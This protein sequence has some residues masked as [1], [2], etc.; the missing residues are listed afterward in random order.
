MVHLAWSLALLGSCASGLIQPDW[1]ILTDFT[2]TYKV[3]MTNLI[4]IANANSPAGRPF[5]FAAGTE[6]GV[7]QAYIVN[8]KL[9]IRSHGRVTFS[10]FAVG[11]EALQGAQVMGIGEFLFDGSA[12]VVAVRAKVKGSGHMGHMGPE[13]FCVKVELPPSMFPPKAMVKAG[14]EQAEQQVD[15]SMAHFRHT[16]LSPSTVKVWL[17]GPS[18]WPPHTVAT[19]IAHMRGSV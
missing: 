5:P 17:C 1:K 2:A 4:A 8:E 18:G 19:P 16:R 12:G 9:H 10:D 15:A 14:L 11:G 3:D 7:I 6:S 13:E